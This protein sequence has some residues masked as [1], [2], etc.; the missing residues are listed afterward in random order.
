VQ[1]VHAERAAEMFQNQATMFR[2]VEFADTIAE[3]LVDEPRGH[4]QQELT[5]QR[6]Q[7]PLDAH[8]IL[9][10]AIQH[11]VPDFIVVMGLGEHALGSVP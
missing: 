2:H 6:R 1:F 3:P 7:E 11:Q 4:L 5:P 8:P 9:H 10:D